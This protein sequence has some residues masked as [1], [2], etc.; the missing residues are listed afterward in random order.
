MKAGIKILTAISEDL[1]MECSQ[2]M[3]PNE[4]NGNF[5][6]MM[7][8]LCISSHFPDVV[9]LIIRANTDFDLLNYKSQTTEEV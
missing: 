3:Y 2:R 9:D 8:M 4:Q 1:F 6:H 5:N 7:K